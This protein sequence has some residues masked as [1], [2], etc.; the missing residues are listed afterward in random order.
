M[1]L[2][3]GTSKNHPVTTATDVGNYFPRDRKHHYR[4]GFSMAEAAK[5]WVAAGGRLP[6]PIAA[7][8]GTDEIESAHF[9]F[10]SIVWGGGTAMT[11]IMAFLSHSVIAVEAKMNEPFDNL[12]ADWIEKEAGKNPASPPHRMGVIR[13]YAHALGV[14]LE[15]LLE[16]RYQLLQR[17]LC[18]ALTALSEGKSQAWMIVQSFSPVDGKDHQRNL[19]DFARFQK[20]VGNAPMLEN[21]CVKIVWTDSPTV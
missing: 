21:V 14:D 1:K 7:V 8:V 19:N 5:C 13:R 6:S 10:P 15:G 9:E 3:F 16:T 4:D 20:L 17:T 12:V 18:A 11:D 2:F